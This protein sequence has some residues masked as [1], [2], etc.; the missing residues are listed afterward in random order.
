MARTTSSEPD[1]QSS[2]FFSTP[3]SPN[4]H[5]QLARRF[6]AELGV[7]LR[8]AT[9]R[10]FSAPLDVRTSFDGSIDGGGSPSVR[11]V[12]SL[13]PGP[14]AM[15]ISEEALSRYFHGE[16]LSTALGGTT[17]SSGSGGAAHPLPQLQF[18]LDLD[19]SNYIE[20][21][22]FVKKISDK[23]RDPVL[24]L[25]LAN[26]LHA[27]RLGSEALAVVERVAELLFDWK[28]TSENTALY[29][30]LLIKM[31]MRYEGKHER[32]KSIKSI[33]ASAVDAPVVFAQCG[34]YMH[35]LQ[36]LSRAEDL[37]TAALL[38]DPLCN[39]AN[40]GL[41]HVLIE[42]GNP[43]AAIRYL[44]RVSDTSALF[45]IVKTEQG[46]LQ[47]LLGAKDE[48]VLLCYKKTLAL[49]LRDRATVC[50]LNSLGHF[51]HIRGDYARASSFY[52]RSLMYSPC[53]SQALLLSATLANTAGTATPTQT[54]AWLRKGVLMQQ[55]DHARWIALLLQSDALVANFQDF[56]KAEELLWEAVRLVFSSEVWPTVALAH[57]YQ[58]TRG[59]L[60][61]ARR[62]L[63][64]ADR[65][66]AQLAANM[67]RPDDPRSARPTPEQE[68]I[69][70]M[71]EKPI[72]GDADR[73]ALLV[74][75]GYAHVDA[76]GWEA[77]GHCGKEALDL[78]PNFTSAHRLLGLVSR[79]DP[80]RAKESQRWFDLSLENAGRNPYTYRTA[81]VVA[82]IEG[83]F[84]Q[85]LKLMESAV[86]CGPNCQLAWR[87][88][89]SM[90]YLYARRV[91][92]A[93]TCLSKAIELS[94]GCDYDA[95]L[96]RGQILL[97]TG[98]HAQ[99]RASFQDALRLQPGDPVL[100]ASLALALSALGFKPPTGKDLVFD[101]SNQ[102][103]LLDSLG[104]LVHSENP[105]E[106]FTAAV[107]EGLD[108]TLR[109]KAQER[110]DSE[111]QAN[112]ENGGGGGVRFR[113]EGNDSSAPAE[114]AKDVDPCVLYWFGMYHMN[115]GSKK[116]HGKAKSFFTRA[117]QRVDHP[118]HPLALYML[119][120]LA[121][122][123]GDLSTAEKYYCYALQL[124]PMHPL[125]FLQLV[126]LAHDTLAFVRGLSVQIEAT[127]SSRKKAIRR[128]NR[129]R[130]QGVSV[131]VAKEGQGASKANEL[132]IAKKRLLLHERVLRLSQLR[133]AQFGSKINGLHAPGKCVHIDPFWLERL[134][135]A[136]TQCED[137]ASLLRSAGTGFLKMEDDP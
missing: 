23:P 1:G 106:L 96:L 85:A 123:R 27:N 100:L 22:T 45:S 131:P 19:D 105:E 72:F 94:Q 122:L 13:S 34:Q 54:D 98:K 8:G 25:E 97:E 63:L 117:V 31:R 41:A 133:M 111:G 81:S 17:K 108:Y 16:A 119:G 9:V 51:Y 102:L 90:L 35:K 128:K 38:L 44:V 74:A 107:T 121:E 32:L 21:R 69:E 26:F 61:R 120:W 47:E 77:A 82:A 52:K 125:A 49:G 62:L 129:L 30:M 20:F 43:H 136:F 18:E 92:A 114:D 50:T 36:H 53:D 79:N 73:A 99:A 132:S 55:G 59:D 29:R 84:G 64:W 116:A 24:L 126:Q 103:S 70:A 137:W 5:G 33:A 56:A 37:Y 75:T 115:K 118:P 127:E 58:Y 95:L 104:Q 80:R 88:L 11:G 48:A 83:N 76:G 110:R 39:E 60:K 2:P 86:Q 6:V 101:Y 66:N 68:E 57:F 15:G 4:P 134:L 40:R 124:E 14:G 12:G 87:A 71:N 89:G 93:L 112:P 109:K 113:P 130:Q 3:S 78:A 10:P 7:P 135:H 42:K 65:R 91:D 67:A 46:W 28:L